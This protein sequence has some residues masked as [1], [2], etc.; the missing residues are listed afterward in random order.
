MPRIRLSTSL[1]RSCAAPTPAYAPPQTPAPA[2][3][4]AGAPAPL[5]ATRLQNLPRALH[6]PRP[7]PPLHRHPCPHRPP[8]PHPPRLDQPLRSA[9]PRGPKSTRPPPPPPDLH[10]TGLG[11]SPTCAGTRTR[12]SI[13]QTI[14]PTASLQPCGIDHS[15]L[16]ESVT[17]RHSYHRCSSLSRTLYRLSPTTPLRQHLGLYSSRHTPPL[18]PATRVTAGRQQPATSRAGTG[19]PKHP[20]RQAYRASPPPRYLIDTDPHHRRPTRTMPCP[21]P[22][23]SDRDLPPGRNTALSTHSAR[24]APCP[25]HRLC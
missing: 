16:L 24:P 20:T 4:P 21:P 23:D 18:C 2:P 14:F 13:G 15:C 12:P 25:A 17:V 1:A 11:P 3:L 6:Q 8:C 10:L 9:P 19:L 22:A 5:P 7:T